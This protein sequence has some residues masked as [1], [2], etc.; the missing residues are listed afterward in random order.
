MQIKYNTINI[1]LYKCI[2]NKLQINNNSRY[3]INP[4]GDE[5]KNLKDYFKSDYIFIDIIL[6][7]MTSQ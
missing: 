3:L 5:K 1:H 6:R 2:Q 4:Q 7:P